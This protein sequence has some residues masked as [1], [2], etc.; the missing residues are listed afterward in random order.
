MVLC[1]FLFLFIFYVYCI[2]RKEPKIKKPIKFK[3]KPKHKKYK[4]T[5]VANA[6]TDMPDC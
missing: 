2:F 6:H 5:Y 3:T 1:A 4:N